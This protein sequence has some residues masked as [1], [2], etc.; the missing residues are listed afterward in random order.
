MENK[1]IY[2]HHSCFLVTI[3]STVFLFD[4]PEDVHL[5]AGCEDIVLD[6]LKEKEQVFVFFSHS[7]DDHFNQNIENKLKDVKNVKY[8]ISDDIIDMYDDIFTSEH[9]IVE[10]DEEY[11]YHQLKIKT[12][13]SNDLG[14]AY[15]IKFR[16]ITIYYGGDLAN[17]I[18]PNMPKNAK[19]ESEKFFKATLERLSKE[20]IKIGFSNV[21]FRLQNLGG[22]K[23]FLET[24]RPKYFVPIHLFS[25]PS[26]IDKFIKRVHVKDT[27][28]F[29]YKKPG[30]FLK[31][32]N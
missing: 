14:V 25:D 15:L 13:L 4:Y 32:E 27:I 24:V 8:I 7:H 6:N 3:N 16:D 26:N 5:P 21:D 2:I 11:S 31:I 10:P 18:W 29:R 23:E 30:D 19:E 28:I 20:N 9:L 22:G 1:I 17:W 12:F